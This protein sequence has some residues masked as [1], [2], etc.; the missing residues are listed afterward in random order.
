MHLDP[1][2]KD[3]AM[4]I[5]LLSAVLL[6]L[7]PA[8]VVSQEKGATERTFLFVDDHDIL[9]RAGTQRVFQTPKRH[10]DKALLPM[11]KPWEVGIGYTSIH[12][13]LKTGTYQLWYQA[14]AGARAGDPALKCVVCYAE[15]KDGIHFERP[16]LDLFPYKGE[17][18]NIVLVSNAH[19]GDRYCCSV[20]VD[21][22]EKNPKRRYKMAYYDWSLVDSRPE[23]GLHVAFSPDGVRWT[24]H[25]G[26]LLKTLYGGRGLQP[27]YTDESGYKETP[28]KGKPAR[29]SWSYPLTLSDVIDV[30]WDPVRQ[31][32]VLLGKFWL[33]GP[34]GGAGWRNGIMRAESKDFVSWSKP[35]IVFTPDDDDSPHIDFHGAPGF[36]HKGR[37]FALN[38]LLDRRGKL[39][40]DIELM[41]SRDG[42]AWERPF[43]KTLFLPRSKPGLFDSRTILSSSTPIILDDEMRFYYGAAN[44]APLDGVKSEPGERS[45][46]GM[47]SLPLDRFA[48]LKTVAKSAQTTLRKPLENIGQITLRPLDL[49]NRGPIQFNAD[50][51]NGAVRVEILTE[52]GYRV[53]GFSRDDAVVIQGDSLRHAVAWQ[54]SKLNELPSGRYLLR[55]HLEN[56]TVFALTLR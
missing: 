14:Y 36:H 6:G 47:A 5:M 18:S 24:K 42:I 39:A 38:Q 17:K 19:Y 49:R 13:D 35:Q 45:G 26:T 1:S 25:G 48:G 11:A 28:V 40:I 46:V 44:V 4:R 12:R 33:D 51:R 34:D 55:L 22:L 31:V 29:K 32:F 15:S 50:A 3:S 20:L 16:D 41:T 53:R 7:S 37:S 52:D 30:F 56:A 43:R 10:G 54:K 27:P 21:P 8:F 23:P 9:Y 2:D